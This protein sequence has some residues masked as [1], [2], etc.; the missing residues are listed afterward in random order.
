ML[1]YVSFV[2]LAGQI[3]ANL[4]IAIS[5][6][7]RIRW[8]NSVGLWESMAPQNPTIG[9]LLWTDFLIKLIIESNETE[10][11]GLDLLVVLHIICFTQY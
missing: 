5:V 4:D 11:A 8:L 7:T 6:G 3:M 2:L 1:F 9:P 10:E